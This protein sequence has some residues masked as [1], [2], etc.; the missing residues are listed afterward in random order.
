VGY[1]LAGRGAIVTAELESIRLVEVAGAAVVARPIRRAGRLDIT[2][3]VDD[4]SDDRLRV[5]P[6]SGDAEGVVAVRRPE[7]VPRPRRNEWRERK[8]REIADE[9]RPRH[10][11]T[12]GRPDGNDA[13]Q[14]RSA[15]APVDVEPI[16][17]VDPGQPQPETGPPAERESRGLE[18]LMALPGHPLP[19]GRAGEAPLDVEPRWAGIGAGR[20]AGI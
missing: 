11:G 8:F 20:D 5:D 17:G 18:R 3:A 10:L 2:V 15:E 9:L 13:E 1:P 7:E 4:E 16:F 6:R 19:A 14:A 12:A